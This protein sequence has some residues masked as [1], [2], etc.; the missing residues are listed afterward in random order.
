MISGEV[1]AAVREKGLKFGVYHSLY[2]WFNPIYL[3]DKKNRYQ[4]QD[5]VKVRDSLEIYLNWSHLCRF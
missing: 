3:N 2:E 4:T 5:Y 1:A